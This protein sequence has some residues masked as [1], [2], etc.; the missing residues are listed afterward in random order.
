MA[1]G[2]TDDA[3]REFEA[4]KAANPLQG[5]VY[6][7]LGDAYSRAARYP[8][9]EQVLRQA[10][11][12]E[13]NATGPLI[14]L[15]KVLLK[16]GQPVGASTF[17]Q[18]AETMDPANYRT[19]NLLAQAYRAMGRTEDARRELALTEKTQAADEPVLQAPK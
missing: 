14:L 1:G 12:L 4:E 19:H 10:L 7:S 3:I 8:E 16:E 9:G 13:P 18:R 6:E 2:H 11:L 17:L 5:V 15:G